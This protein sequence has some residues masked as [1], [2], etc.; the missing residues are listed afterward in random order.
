M[1]A[2]VR[3]LGRGGKKEEKVSQALCTLI[4][5][6][7]DKW[8]SIPERKYYASSLSQQL[9]TNHK[10]RKEHVRI[11]HEMLYGERPKSEKFCPY[12][13]IFMRSCSS[14]TF[15]MRSIG[16]NNNLLSPSSRKDVAN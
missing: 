6:L 11:V 15:T 14:K 7:P 2:Y 8:F 12:G 9:K 4:H 3:L 5:F 13:Y 16:N 10:G 1:K